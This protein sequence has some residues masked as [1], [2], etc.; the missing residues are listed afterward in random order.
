M[1]GHFIVE[2]A[3]INQLGGLIMRLVV[4]ISKQLYNMKKYI[5][6]NSLMK[7][8]WEF[9]NSPRVAG[10]KTVLNWDKMF[11]QQR[12]VLVVIEK[13]LLQK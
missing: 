13:Y 3:L 4:R 1:L 2:T 12:A 7:I 9:T 10:Q 11:L 5:P 8:W 6:M